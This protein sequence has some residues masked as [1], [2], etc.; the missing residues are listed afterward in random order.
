MQ[1]S[2]IA[3][4]YE[5]FI[6][7]F[8][9][10]PAGDGQEAGALK[11]AFTYAAHKS[12]VKCV[13][14]YGSILASGGADDTIHLFDLKGPKDL[15]F[16][17]NPC[18]GA[19]TALHMVTPYA[20]DSPSHMLSGSQDGG[21]TVWKVGSWQ[22]L[23]SMR[24]HTKEINGLA[25][26]PSGTVVLSVA[27]DRSLK[28]WNLVT[29]KCGYTTKLELEAQD[30]Q[31]D[32]TGMN[33]ALQ[34]GS[35]LSLHN[36]ER[37]EGVVATFK[38][39]GKALCMTW[40]SMHTLLAGSDDGSLRMFDIRQPG[41][42]AAWS[43]DK[44]HRVRIK[45]VCCIAAPGAGGPP[46]FPEGAAIG[47]ASNDGLVK[48]W[49]IRQLGKTGEQPMP[50]AEASTGARFTCLSGGGPSPGSSSRQQQQL[51]QHSGA[52]KHSRQRAEGAGQQQ[53]RQQRNDSSAGVSSLPKKGPKRQV[54][55][56]QA[57]ASKPR[58]GSAGK[59]AAP[60][61]AAAAVVAAGQGVVVAGK[62]V[63]EFPDDP[64]EQ[65]RERK[66]VKLQK[67]RQRQQG[68]G[69]AGRGRQHQ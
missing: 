20:K 37:T 65:Q 7:G 32:G 26:H 50:L 67:K 31:F 33:Y 53:Q 22:S 40:Q 25:V 15:G 24:G 28:L 42:E 61:Q 18:D 1:T 43:V 56:L 64:G 12:P 8:E 47:T 45:G 3:G 36:V 63:V 19:V 57:S 21:I 23:K 9:F 11:R 68:G 35:L 13:V 29:G 6:F 10:S 69:S 30:V 16:L 55:E 58:K 48:L 38:V 54:S 39:P 52:A 62:G 17:M 2:L 60:N 41:G 66:K 46:M 4:S 27:H 49:D 14:R 34:C 51:P 59:A 5:R 44:A